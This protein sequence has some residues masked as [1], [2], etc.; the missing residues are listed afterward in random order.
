MALNILFPPALSP[1]PLAAARACE[2]AVGIGRV[3]GNAR[4]PGK[5]PNGLAIK[6]HVELRAAQ[7]SKPILPV[8]SSTLL[9]DGLDEQDHLRIGVFAECKH[10]S[11][12]NTV[13]R[14][15]VFRGRVAMNRLGQQPQLRPLVVRVPVLLGRETPGK[16]F[17]LA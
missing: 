2:H 11:I 12:D 1:G 13:F 14:G 10:R 9:S 5:P 16:V 8:D 15:D 6:L 17:H 4:C 3:A 7:G